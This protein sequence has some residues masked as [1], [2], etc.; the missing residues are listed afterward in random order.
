MGAGVLWTT[1]ILVRFMAIS[2][3]D[4]LNSARRIGISWMFLSLLGTI[5]IGLAGVVAVG[6]LN[7]PLNDPETI[8]IVLSQ[9]LLSPL[10]AGICLAAIL[11]AIMSTISSQ[12]LVTASALSEDLAM[13]LNIREQHWLSRNKVLVSRLGVIVVAIIAITIAADR[14]SGCSA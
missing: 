10:V 6:K 7:I 12:L 8:V 1:S 14:S 13:S 9:T 4:K 3:V 11:A 2:S 5:I